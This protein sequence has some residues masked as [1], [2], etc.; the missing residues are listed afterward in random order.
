MSA[1]SCFFYKY[2]QISGNSGQKGTFLWLKKALYL[3]THLGKEAKNT[4]VPGL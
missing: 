4:H 1:S 2:F 3:Q